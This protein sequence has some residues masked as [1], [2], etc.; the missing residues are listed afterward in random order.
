MDRHDLWKNVDSYK[1][2]IF[3]KN[4]IK[5]QALK[6]IKKNHY[7]PYIYRNK[8]AFYLSNLPK[9]ATISYLNNRCYVSGRSQSVDRK[10]RTSRFVFRSKIYASDLPGFR[11]ASW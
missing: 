10:T 5:K 8:A 2:K 4:E 3:L 7:L 9:I 1:R 11:R 6:S